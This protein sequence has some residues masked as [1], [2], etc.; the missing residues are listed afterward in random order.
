[1][2]DAVLDLDAGQPAY[3]SDPYPVYAELRRSAP[4]HRIT[5]NGL[6]AWLVTRYEDVRQA[7]ADPRLSNSLD[8]LNPALA[9][10]CPDLELAI[11]PDRIA[12]QVN[13]H[14]RGPAELPVRFT[15]H[16]P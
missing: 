1:V 9:A 5:L 11:D 15:P 6:P 13:P 10:G 3:K 2:S 8:S 16:R 14:L 4:V 12:W 7:L